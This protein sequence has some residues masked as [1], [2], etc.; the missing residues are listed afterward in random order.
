MLDFMLFITGATGFIGKYLI[1][2][3]NK[4]NEQ[5]CCLV[6][7]SEKDSSNDKFLIDN[8][9][10]IEYGDIFDENKVKEIFSKYKFDNVIHLAAIIR[11]DRIEDF[12]EVNVIGTKVIVE[13]CERFKINKLI[14]LSTDFVLYPYR[15]TYRD[16]KLDAENILKNS[17]VNYTILRPTP[18]YGLDDDKNFI[19][20]FPLVKKF[21]ILPAVNC[22]M[23]PVY[24]ED[25]VSAIM[26]CLNNKKT[27]YKSY[28]LPGGSIVSF[29]DILKILSDEMGLKRFVFSV[30]NFIIVPGVRFY[31]K[32]VPNPVIHDYQISKWVLNKPLSLDEQKND[33]KYSPIDFES[34]IRKTMKLM[35]ISKKN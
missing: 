3:L 18:V 7:P 22:V 15:N 20:L 31:E 4:Y 13:N 23:Q 1:R 2:Y 8:N 34:G 9:A 30:P 33:F 25:V 26:S 14:F 6:K 24:V 35:G 10:I 32:I 17:K 11:S 16:T 21:P 29:K 27:D 28:N 19:T 5:F 12:N